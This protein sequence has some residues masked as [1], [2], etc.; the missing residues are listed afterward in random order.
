MKLVMHTGE[1]LIHRIKNFEEL[2]GS[3]VILVHRLLKNSVSAKEYVLMTAETYSQLEGFHQLEPEWRKEVC[4]GF[5]E[6]EVVV[7]YPPEELINVR[8]LE[9]DRART[10]L[11]K[12]IGYRVQFI[13]NALLVQLG[14]RKLPAFHNLPN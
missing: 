5:G 13:S 2:S 11:N 7:F 4:E 10:P 3:D 9:A 6:V 12:K 8:A 1:A 14:L